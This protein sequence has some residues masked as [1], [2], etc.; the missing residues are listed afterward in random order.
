MP[1]L[2]QTRTFLNL[3]AGETIA[4]A[5]AF[6]AMLVVARRLGPAMYGVIGVTSGIMLYLNQIADAGVELAGVPAVAR[7]R[8]RLSE[9]VSSVLSGRVL[10]AGVLTALV[11]VVGLFAF[12][13]PDG[14]ILA[15]YSLGLVFVA[16]GTRWVF[17]G[18]QQ[19]SWV[20]AARISGELTALALIV[21]TLG[22]VGDV[23]VVPVAAVIGLAVAT[24]AMLFGLRGLDVHPR[25]TSD[26]EA[27]R[28]L[29]A[30]GPHLVGFTLLGLVLFNADLIYLRFVAGQSA[31]GYYAAAYTFIAF[32]ANLSVAWAHSVM[33]TMA[34]Y[35]RT[36]T[37][38]NDV[39]ET[40][41]LLAYTVALPVA[42]GGILTATPLI[43]LVFG[44][45]Y[46]PA[47]PALVWLLPAVPIAAVRE[48]AV[49]GL[50]GTEGGERR[51]VRINAICAAFNIAIL[52]PVVPVYGLIGAAVVTVLT[53]ILRLT[54][55]FRFAVE[56]GYRPPGVV[57]FAKP[58][59][60]A[61]AMVPALT[62]LGDRPFP[63]LLTVGAAVY[64][65]VLLVT[66]V[67][68]FRAP[69][70]VRLVV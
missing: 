59:L 27:S 36:D 22:G 23:A 70:A 41:M 15:I 37:G 57:R 32:A 60:A 18:L 67:L 21:I 7:Q 52:I 11:V 61:G 65:G 1:D 24:C 13:Q 50:I 10:L 28:T 62:L 2:R 12:P 8:D 35:E 39:Y 34:R 30:R 9:L 66:G 31:A 26:R 69:F 5:L 20:A 33:P 49:V 46:A 3:A 42:V 58:T 53:E 40:S 55:A 38:R 16:L 51:L 14:A 29:F 54:I 4:R 48:I 19:A 44:G 17:L 43:R 45:D 63:L 64:A 47:V 68:R 56:A 25:L 6:V